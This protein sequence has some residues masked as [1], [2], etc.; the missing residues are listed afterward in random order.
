MAAPETSDPSTSSANDASRA[1]EHDSSLRSKTRRLLHNIGSRRGSSSRARSIPETDT[2]TGDSPNTSSDELHAS[3][4][5]SQVSGAHEVPVLTSDE[6]SPATSVLVNLN[7]PAPSED[8]PAYVDARRPTEPITYVFTPSGANAML[9]LPPSQAADSRPLYHI[10]VA[11]NV[12]VPTS[13]ITTVRRGGT[14]EGPIVGD[15]EMGISNKASTVFIRNRE[16]TVHD[17]LHPKTFKGDILTWT[18]TDKE[19]QWDITSDPRLY[20]CFRMEKAVMERVVLARFLPNRSLRL[21]DARHRTQMLEVTPA[22]QEFLDD[23]LLSALII[24]RRRRR[25]T[26]HTDM[27][28]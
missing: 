13:F 9:L 19:I 14:E 2:P 8:P 20:I 15:F 11:M 23:I 7:E 12:F 27:F 22:G 3:R 18:L 1:S 25:P 16:C 10:S 24:E 28:N 17:A 5:A 6:G 26:R 4:E 21:P